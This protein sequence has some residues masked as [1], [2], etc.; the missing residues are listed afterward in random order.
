[1][2]DG[3][4]DLGTLGAQV[5]REFGPAL[6][7]GVPTRTLMLASE[8]GELAKEAVKCTGYGTRGFQVTDAFREEL[9]DVLLD[10]LLLTD[11]AGVDIQTC[12]AQTLAK[13]RAR[14]AER[15]HVGSETA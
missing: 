10:L 11:E 13:M 14:L 6:A 8:V 5:R 3:N 1:M 12:A 9:G 2:T 4:L 7:S 15:G